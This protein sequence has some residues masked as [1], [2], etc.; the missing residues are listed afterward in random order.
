MEKLIN[1]ILNNKVILIILALLIA[2][3]LGEAIG[4]GIGNFFDQ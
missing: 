2:Y 4:K 1:T 3:K